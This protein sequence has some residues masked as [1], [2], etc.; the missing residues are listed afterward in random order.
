MKEGW[1]DLSTGQE[2]HARGQRDAAHDALVSSGFKVIRH[3][4]PPAIAE[5]ENAFRRVV[6]DG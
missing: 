2:G 4:L 3:K 1:A 6:E 5:V